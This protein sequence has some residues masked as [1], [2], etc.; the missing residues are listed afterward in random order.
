MQHRKKAL[1]LSIIPGLGQFYN[2]Q[3]I[4]GLLFLLLGVSFFAVF[5]DLLN[6]G[7]WGLFTLGTEVPRDNSIFLLAKG[8][9]AVIVTCFGLAVYYANLRDAYQNGKRRDEQ[10][11]LSSLKEQYH[12]LIAQ[13]YPYL[14]S[15]PSLFIL[16]FAVV[17]PIL[18]SFALAFTNYNLYH[19]PP[20]RLVDWVGI[21][22]FSEI[23]TVDI[24]RSTFLDVLAWTIVWTLV[25]STLQVGL[26]ILLAV[27]VNQKEVRFK[28]IFRTILVLPWAVPGF[29][30][31]LVFAGLFND[32][33]GAFNHQILAAFGIDP[34]PWMT[35]ANWTKLALILMQGWLGF[36]YVFIVT[37]GVL[38]SIP[39]DLYEAATIDGASAFSKFRHITLPLILI[40]MA[41]IIITQFTFNFNNF[42]IIYLFNG[43]GP[44]VPGST[45]GGTDILVSWIYKLTMQSSQ[46]SLAAA[47][48]ILLSVFVISIALW[49]FRRTNSF[50]EGA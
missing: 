41:P 37:T 39:D 5:G 9:I 6:M 10:K 33:F 18:F 46:Y 13:G 28:K 43:G 20:A 35:N 30:T 1:L 19:S 47:L 14:I 48:T 40:A 7:L 11:E 45:A 17:F 34:I 42:N 36:P 50:K 25:A 2:K 16:V 27:V 22:T 44:A 24:W 23:F 4:K 3:W 12:N 31:I 21:K 8:I 15:G 29:V 26:G 49:Q 38:Q 32:S